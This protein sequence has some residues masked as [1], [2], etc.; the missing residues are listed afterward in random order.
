MRRLWWLACLATAALS[1]AAQP[2]PASQDPPPSNPN[3]P[4][5][6]SPELE[7]LEIFV[8]AWRVSET[9]FNPRGEIVAQARG[10]EEIGWTLDYHWIRRAY[11]SSGGATSYRATGM[12]GWNAAEKKYV[13]HWYDNVSTLGPTNVKGDWNQE[14]K[15][16]ILEVGSTDADGK[17]IHH[18]VVE[19]FD[20]AEQRTAT[21]YLA[22]GANLVK[23]LEVVYQRTMPC[24]DKI[25]TFFGG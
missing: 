10:M 24:P 14:T 9:H 1:L 16:M 6:A 8:G 21:T 22:D 4:E 19:K 13:G 5:F 3:A 23:R 11:S 20:G 15:T 17:P 2:Q 7:R 25:R 12:L 18:R